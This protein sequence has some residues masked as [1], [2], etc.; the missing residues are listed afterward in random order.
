MSSKVSARRGRRINLLVLILCV[1]SVVGDT[2]GHHLC[3][4]SLSVPVSISGC[5]SLKPWHC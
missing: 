3:A 1:D 4:L 2:K 5:E